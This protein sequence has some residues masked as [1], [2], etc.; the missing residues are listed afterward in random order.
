MSSIKLK[1]QDRVKVISGKS[2]GQEGRIIKVL[3]ETGRVVVEGVN[4]VK[5]HQK[6]SQKDQKGGI[7][8]KEM[9]LHISNVML[10]SAKSNGPVK[11]RK[12]VESGK[13][14]RVEAKTGKALD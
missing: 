3:A 14:V 13:R 2:K 6:P 8:E 11:V 5:K 10:V 12:T 9:S 4:K 7:I 1:K